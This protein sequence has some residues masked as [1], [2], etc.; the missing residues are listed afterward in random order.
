MTDPELPAKSESPAA[1]PPPEEPS[2][3]VRVLAEVLFWMFAGV[4]VAIAAGW[5]LIPEYLDY[6]AVLEQTREV[7]YEVA[8]LELRNRQYVETLEALAKDPGFLERTLRS[9]VPAPAAEGEPARELDDRAPELR[10]PEPTEEAVRAQQERIPDV[11][12]LRVE[13]DRRWVALFTDHARRPVLLAIA[14]GCLTI[15]FAFFVPP[16]RP[17][18]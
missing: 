9:R 1:A 8:R 16:H 3:E 7:R 6:L 18:A 15:A 13:L 2:P 17:G 5:V 14:V 4:G 12:P 11:R 10:L